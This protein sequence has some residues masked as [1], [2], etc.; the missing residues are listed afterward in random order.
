MNAQPPHPAQLLDAIPDP[1][2]HHQPTFTYRTITVP[3]DAIRHV[4]DLPHSPITT[5]CQTTI[6]TLHK[7]TR[8]YPEVLCWQC[9]TL[10]YESQGRAHTL[11]FDQLDITTRSLVEQ[12]P[13]V[14]LP[15]PQRLR[16]RIMVIDNLLGTT[17]YLTF[18]AQ[19]KEHRITAWADTPHP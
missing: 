13:R 9:L 19:H 11:T 10:D 6:H 7:H 14:L 16:E 3:P 5:Y 17:V 8:R 4:D 12:I 2:T 1:L 15:P 18:E